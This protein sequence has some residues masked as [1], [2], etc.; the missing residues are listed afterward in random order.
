MLTPQNRIILVDD[1][2]SE[3]DNLTEVFLQTGLGCRPF[4]YEPTY[5]TPLKDIRLAFFDINITEKS[6]DTTGLSQEEIEKANTSIYNDLAV[7][8]NQYI[9]KENGPFALVFWTKNQPLVSGFLKYMQDPKRGF[10]DTAKPFLIDSWDKTEIDSTNIEQKL[11]ELLSNDKVKFFF[12]IEEFSRDAGS[13]TIGLLNSIIPKDENW[14]ENKMYFENLDKVLSKISVNVLGFEFA[15]ESPISGSYIGLSQII[16]KEF[17]DL[18]SSINPKVLLSTLDAATKFKDVAFPEDF[19]QSKLNSI[20]HITEGEYEKDTRGCMIELDKSKRGLLNW[21]NIKNEDINVWF[22]NLIPFK[23]EASAK[24]KE[25][26]GDS[27][28]IC[29]EISAACD[30]SNKKPRTN[31]YILGFLTPSFDYKENIDSH[32]RSDFSYHLGGSNFMINGKERQIWLNMNYVFS[33]K[34]D[35]PCLGNSICKLNKEIM[36]MLGHKYASH[37]SRIGITSF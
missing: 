3:L 21:L 4:E 8:I 34:K 11:N 17:L 31:E 20:F 7:A 10:T 12:E 35:A 33:A 15:K 18:E 29:I 16:L 5:S 26:R 23:K 9:D 36:D 24:K 37:I 14:G 2:K 6:V 25:V 30:Y 22:N 28:F 13:K 27:K 1:Q 19:S 32:R